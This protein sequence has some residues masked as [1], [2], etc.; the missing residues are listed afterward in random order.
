MNKEFTK[1]VV[2]ISALALLV[3]I[4]IIKWGFVDTRA[5]Q[6]AQEDKEFAEAMSEVDTLCAGMESQL[7]AMLSLRWEAAQE[8]YAASLATQAAEQEF[9]FLEIRKAAP[10]PP[11]RV[12]RELASYV[13]VQAYNSRIVDT[14]N[15]I[16]DPDAFFC[17]PEVKRIIARLYTVMSQSKAALT[18]IVAD[19]DAA[20]NHTAEA[21]AIREATA[22]AFSIG[23]LEPVRYFNKLSGEYTGTPLFPDVNDTLD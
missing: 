20:N 15:I 23:G 21:E 3:T 2:L 6:A 22:V 12:I 8:S 13:Y 17:N 14:G 5:A 19:L 18:S 10:T 1:S 4:G 11:D 7:D 16:V 9:L